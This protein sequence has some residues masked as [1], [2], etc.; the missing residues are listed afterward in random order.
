MIT[1]MIMIMTTMTTMMIEFTQS[2]FG[3][4]RVDCGERSLTLEA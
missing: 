1:T 2:V 3:I 4:F